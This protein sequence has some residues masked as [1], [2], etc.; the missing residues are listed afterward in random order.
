VLYHLFAVYFM[1]AKRH[2]WPSMR[3]NQ[4]RLTARSLTFQRSQQ[5]GILLD[6][7]ETFGWWKAYKNFRKLTWKASLQLFH[8]WESRWSMRRISSLARDQLVR[9][10]IYNGWQGNGLLRKASTWSSGHGITSMEF[11]LATFRTMIEGNSIMPKM[12]DMPERHLIPQ[13][14]H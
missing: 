12:P 5:R 1:S 9:L 14:G 13:H 7:W 8:L 10:T 4:F 3:Q 6:R 11:P 2:F